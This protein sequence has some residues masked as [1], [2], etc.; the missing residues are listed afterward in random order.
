MWSLGKV[1]TREDIPAN[2]ALALH[3]RNKPTGFRYVSCA[4]I[5]PAKPS[6]L[7]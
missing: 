5:K 3:M 1:L 4:W 7:G 6:L 2:G